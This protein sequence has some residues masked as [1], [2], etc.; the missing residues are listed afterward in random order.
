MGT[1]GTPLHA[2]LSVTVWRRPA[3]PEP[4]ARFRI[5]ADLTRDAPR[6][7]PNAIGRLFHVGPPSR[8][9]RAPGRDAPR[10]RGHSSRSEQ[11]FRE[12]A[13]SDDIPANPLAEQETD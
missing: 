12:G 2:D 8:F 5:D 11:V 10:R 3:L 1:E 6:Q 4:A 7:L 9:G 13:G